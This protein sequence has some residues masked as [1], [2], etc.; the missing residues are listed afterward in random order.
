[1]Y[2]DTFL[3]LFTAILFTTAILFYMVGLDSPN[4]KLVCGP[5]STVFQTGSCQI[6]WSYLLLIFTSSLCF[7]LPVLSH[8]IDNTLCVKQEKIEPPEYAA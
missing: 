8:Y 1:M 5:T 7:I 6:G 3:C 2:I 4:V